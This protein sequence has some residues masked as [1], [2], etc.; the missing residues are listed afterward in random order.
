MTQHANLNKKYLLQKILIIMM[1]FEVVR[2]P[3]RALAEG[4]LQEG[5]GGPPPSSWHSSTLS[6]F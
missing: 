6:F 3:L 2:R 1:C 5:L 4:L